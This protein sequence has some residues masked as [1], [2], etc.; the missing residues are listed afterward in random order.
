MTR[1]KKQKLLAASVLQTITLTN[2]D[3]N[4]PIVKGKGKETIIITDSDESQ[5]VPPAVVKKRCLPERKGRPRQV[6]RASA[7]LVDDVKDQVQDI[8]SASGS[9]FLPTEKKKVMENEV[10][11]D[12]DEEGTTSDDSK[13][14]D[15]L[16][17]PISHKQK[18]MDNKSQWPAKKHVIIEL[19]CMPSLTSKQ[20]E[21][22]PERTARKMHGAS[23]AVWS[24]KP[25]EVS[26]SCHGYSLQC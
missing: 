17:M 10:A 2:S 1:V 9:E 18:A 12:A 21:K 5:E 15:E 3:S 8:S 22:A 14:S 13:V 11:S 4:I 23:I 24:E 25:E 16:V 20:K 7:T 6:N 19:T 26:L